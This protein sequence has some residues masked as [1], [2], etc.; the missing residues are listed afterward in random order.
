MEGGGCVT[1]SLRRYDLLM[2][3]PAGGT[4]KECGSTLHP[5]VSRGR[6]KEFCDP[7]CRMRAYR[8][9]NPHKNH[10]GPHK[11][12]ESARRRQQREQEWTDW[13]AR[14]EREWERGQKRA[15]RSYKVE[16]LPT[17]EWTRPCPTDAPVQ[18]KKR[19]KCFDLMKLALRTDNVDEATSAR[20]AAERLRREFAL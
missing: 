11:Q 17:P 14:Q 20:E 3:K 1:P 18:R 19:A 2:S 9:R 12:S 6:T 8:R 4:C 5:D 7:A 15:G 16:Q 13:K 10:S